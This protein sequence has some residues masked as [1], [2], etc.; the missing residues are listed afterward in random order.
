[1]KNFAIIGAVLVVATT[2]SGPALAQTAG[3]SVFATQLS[4]DQEV[5]PVTTS[6]GG[7]AL[8]FVDDAKTFI[9]FRLLANG[10]TDLLGAAG[11]HIHCA[12]AGSNGPVILNL[13]G[14]VPGGFSGTFYNQATLDEDNIVNGS[15]GDTLSEIVDS[16]IAGNTYVNVHSSTVPSGEVRGQI[17][18]ISK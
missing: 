10:G 1:M 14:T 3:Y 4:G 15:C 6:A 17:S 7:G 5:P 2:L 16:M 8:F 18:P 11:A 9:S 13:A 12:P